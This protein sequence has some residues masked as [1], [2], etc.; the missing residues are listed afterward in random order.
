MSVTD[1]ALSI[2]EAQDPAVA[3]AI[4][5]ERNRQLGTLE[6][7]A[8]E[9]FVSRAVQEAAGSVLTNKY[10]E[11]YPGKRYYNGCEPS[12]KVENLAIDRVKQLFGSACANVQSHSG[13]TA[14]QAVFFATMKPGDT[15]LSLSLANGGHLSHGHRVNM[16]GQFF[17]IVN[18]G[19]S[20]DTEQIN[21]DEVAS[22]A[23]EHKPRMIITGGSAYPRLIDFA[24]F[25][26]IAD[27][28]GAVFLVDMAHFAGLVAGK[29]IPSPVPHAHIVSS[30]THKTLRGPRAGIILSDAEWGPKIDKAV[31]PGLQGG[32]L[33]HIVAAKAVAF[34]EALKPSFATYAKQVIRNAQTLGETLVSKGLRLVAGGTDTHLILVDLRNYNVTGKDAANA[35][36]HA[37]ITVNKNA[38]PFD[39]Q[40]EWV[41]SG[42]RIGSP[43]LTSRGMKEAE[44]RTIAG[45]IAEV[46]KDPADEST[47]RR[48]RAQVGELTANYPLRA[49]EA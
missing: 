41:T 37:G 2:L 6:M 10:A 30:T 7:I 40:K 34:G 3:S 32:P 48:V 28:V 35:L 17:K 26:A 1:S 43:A 4:E 42:I 36:E 14:N 25:R 33:M 22:L 46:V 15:V 38:I 11:G 18:Y 24:K 45:W 19:V 27:E 49:D 21:F 12:D 5:E 29:A 31:F 9:N 20:A 16:A 39:P 47:Q 23:R 13:S 44:M 8:S